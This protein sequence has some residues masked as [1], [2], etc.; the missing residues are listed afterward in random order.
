MKQKE[1]VPFPTRVFPVQ[2]FD[3]SPNE[4]EK[5]FVLRKRFF[6]GVA[7]IRKQSEV[8]TVVPI[9]QE[10]NL[11][12]LDQFLDVLR[13]C[14][15]RR[16]HDQSPESGRNSPGEIH[17]RQGTGRHR[18]CHQQVRQRHRQVR[19]AEK[20]QQSEQH[21]RRLS[22]TLGVRFHR[23][24]SRKKDRHQQDASAIQRQGRAAADLPQKSDDR[25][26]PPDQ[27][28]EARQSPAH[29]I[30]SHM[31]R[32]VVLFP[33]RA[34]ESQSDRCTRRLAFG[35][36]AALRDLL[37]GVAIAI[38]GGKIHPLVR[39]AWVFAQC[40]LDD[41]HCL[42][43][44]A[45]VRRS[46]K[47][48]TADTVAHRE[49]IGGL[50]LVFRAHTLFDRPA[51]LGQALFDP[52]ERQRQRRPLALQTTS[53]LR[54]ERTLH[55]RIR[56]RHVGDHEDQTL[57][58]LRR[59]LRHPIG[60]V[61]GAVATGAGRCDPN[62]DPS[63]VLDQGKPQHDGNGPEFAQFQGS[64]RLIGG[65]EAAE[66]FRIHATIAMRDRLQGYVIHAR[67]AGRRTR[68]EAGQFTSIPLRQM[69]PR[70]PDLFLHQIEVIEQPL[71]RRSNPAIKRD[72]LRQKPVN[73]KKDAFVF[74]QPRQKAIPGTPFLQTVRAGEGSSMLLHL[75]DAE[76]LRS[77]GKLITLVCPRPVTSAKERTQAGNNRSNGLAKHLH[78]FSF[79]RI[80]SEFQARE[81]RGES[82]G[83]SVDPA[84]N[85]SLTSSPEI[86]SAY[87]TI[88][89]YIS[90]EGKI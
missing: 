65:D 89:Q 41:A 25:K 60:P 87:R 49:L 76:Q 64:H 82:V 51:R 57:R 14:K 2:L 8:E 43:K 71:P 22:Q 58:I 3:S 38:T 30:E 69:P 13:P 48:E 29:Q 55:R 44:F 27:P 86:P 24:A 10:T 56:A 85:K 42:D 26:A 84:S 11:H 50:S 47:T 61:V 68:R 80:E 90:Q 74:G 46:E 81:K 66:V 73:F 21:Q 78:S 63:E 62:G 32:A 37:H 19:G 39:A 67:K 4:L 40:F 6:G 34:V 31:R 72:I 28:F 23:K 9:R 35:A 79:F 45:P 20:R 75:I 1:N 33:L 53:K 5:R 7:K 52:G 36:G 59:H 77:K 18:Q 70:H 88:R 12:R 16:D 54:D 17:A 83:R 15:H